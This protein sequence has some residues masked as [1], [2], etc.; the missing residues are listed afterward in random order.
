MAHFAKD[1]ASR[2]RIRDEF[3]AVI[4]ER[5][6]EEP[7]LANLPMKDIMKKLITFDNIKDLEYLN[8]VWQEALRYQAPGSAS[9]DLI[10]REDT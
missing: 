4:K 10:F 8:W 9:T 6:Q 1:P 5:V 7:E 2:Q 3:K